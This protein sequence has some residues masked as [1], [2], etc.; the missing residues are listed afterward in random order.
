MGEKSWCNLDLKML[1]DNEG[2]LDSEL[3]FELHDLIDIFV[4][5]IYSWFEQQTN[6]KKTGNHLK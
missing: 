2:Q 6:A 5:M 1:V 4:K 3:K